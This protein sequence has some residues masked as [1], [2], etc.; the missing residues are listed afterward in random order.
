MAKKIQDLK[1]DIILK[2][3]WN[4]KEQF[5][6]L[7]NAVLFQGRTVIRAEEL[8]DMDTEESSLL[9]HREYTESIQ[10]SRDN[11]TYQNLQSKS[12][13]FRPFAEKAEYP[14]TEGP[15]V[16]SDVWKAGMINCVKK[17][18]EKALPETLSENRILQV[19]KKTAV[20]SLILYRSVGTKKLE[21]I[22]ESGYR[23]FP[24]RL[25]D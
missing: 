1:P 6:D 17:S 8:E 14:F 3:Y 15:R 2:N 12:G 19:K 23:K 16:F 10:A 22:R 20:K 5:A 4:N 21:L 7:F 13:Y 18:S 25:P 24:R 9:E 11:I